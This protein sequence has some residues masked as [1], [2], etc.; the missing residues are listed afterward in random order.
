MS[1]Q[2]QNVQWGGT[3]GGDDEVVLN[4]SGADIPAARIVQLDVTNCLGS[5]AFNGGLQS[6]VGV[7]MIAGP[8]GYGITMYDIPAG[9]T[10]VVRK[11]GR[12]PVLANGTFTAGSPVTGSATAAHYG[13]GVACTAGQAQVG[14]CVNTGVSGD[15]MLVQLSDANNA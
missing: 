9:A 7:T 14:R 5:T 6:A 15:T 11:A 1:D 4:T 3:Y 10:G 12:A 13:Q 8:G 2:N